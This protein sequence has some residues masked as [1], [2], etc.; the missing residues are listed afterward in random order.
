MNP[1]QKQLT[2]LATRAWRAA[3]EL[4]RPEIH[5]TAR[6]FAA[7]QRENGAGRGIQH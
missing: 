5:S 4:Q 3:N 2:A 7:N 6:E 1:D